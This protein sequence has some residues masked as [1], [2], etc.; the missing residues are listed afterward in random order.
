M[1]RILHLNQSLIDLNNQSL[2]DSQTNQS[3]NIRLYD[4]KYNPADIAATE[5]N[6]PAGYKLPIYGLA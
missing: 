3:I 1:Q 6:I 2:I 4:R 5:N